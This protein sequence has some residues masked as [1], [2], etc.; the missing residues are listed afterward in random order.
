MVTSEYERTLQEVAQVAVP[1]IADWCTFTLV[2]RRGVLRT[3]AVAAADPELERVAAEMTL[4]YPPRMDAPAGVGHVITTGES[5]LVADV[6][7]ELIDR[8]GRDAEHLA[9]LRRLGLRSGLT[10]PLKVGGRVIG[11]L[12]SCT[13]PRGARTAPTT[14]RSPS[15]SPSRAALAV[16]NARLLDERSHIAQ[17]LQRSLLPPALPEVE[18]P[19]AGRA[20]PRRGRPERG[21]R[22]LLRRLPRRRRRVDVRDRRRVGQGRRGGGG[23]VADAPHAARRVAARDPPSETLELLNDALLASP[24]PA[25]ASAPCCWAGVR[26]TADGLDLTAG[27]GR[28]PADRCR[29]G[30]RP[31]RAASSCAGRSW[32]GLDRPPSASATCAWGPATARDVHD[33]VTEIRSREPDFGEEQPRGGAARARAASPSRRSSPR[34]EERAGRAAGRRARATSPCSRCARASKIGR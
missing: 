1:S 21:R 8:F 16:D 11:A 29:A 4:R 19:R 2:E 22:R 31:G 34:V 27:H 30:G 12:S 17:T 9:F 23:D 5:Q 6:P 26:V 20:L 32:A 18:G 7:A 25:G 10:V 14:S 15:R 3:V 24:I 28:A 13:R 33:G